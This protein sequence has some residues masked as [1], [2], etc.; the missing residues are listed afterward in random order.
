MTWL[1]TDNWSIFAAVGLQ[2]PKHIDLPEGCV[3]PNTNFAANDEGCNVADPKRAP[4]ETITL[5]TTLDLNLGFATLRPFASLRYIGANVVGTGNLG[6][7]G[8][9]TLWNGGVALVSNR[10]SSEAVVE[11]RNCTNEIYT[12]SFLFVPYYNAPGAWQALVRFKL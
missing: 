9:T 7:N 12:T 2:N 8:S 4:D 10:G 6:A 5:G 1:P 11:C 3:V